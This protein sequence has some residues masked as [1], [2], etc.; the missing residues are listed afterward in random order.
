MAGATRIPKEGGTFLHTWQLLTADATGDA[1]SIPGAAD[2][3]IQFVGANWGGATVILEGSLDG[4]NWFSL[5]DGQGNAI[6]FITNAN[7]VGGEFVAENTLHL[8]P[9]LSVGGTLA[10]VTVLLL[11]RSTM[12]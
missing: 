1:I 8:R 10:D 7:N 4:I 12:R 9:R 3:T 6:S 11:S 2:R 5:T